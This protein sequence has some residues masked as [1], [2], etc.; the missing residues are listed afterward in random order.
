MSIVHEFWSFDTRRAIDVGVV[1][2]WNRSREARSNHNGG[3]AATGD[4]CLSRSIW[5]LY[6]HTWT[7]IDTRRYTWTYTQLPGK[8]HDMPPWCIDWKL[9]LQVAF[10]RLRHA[11]IWISSCFLIKIPH[12]LAVVIVISGRMYILPLFSRPSVISPRCLPSTMIDPRFG[13]GWQTKETWMLMLPNTCP[14]FWL[15]FLLS[16]WNLHSFLVR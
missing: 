8:L 2:G 7:Q 3:A 5:A 15:H 9:G 4:F 6:A 10:W 16:C 13:M 12:E 14:L 11:G 1:E